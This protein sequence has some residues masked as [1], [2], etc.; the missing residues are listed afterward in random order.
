MSGEPYKM[1]HINSR[2]MTLSRYRVRSIR[3]KSFTVFHFIFKRLRLVLMPHSVSMMNVQ[4]LLSLKTR[5]EFT[6]SLD[7]VNLLN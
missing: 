3:G 7:W 2:L 4:S 1:K 5:G 6:E